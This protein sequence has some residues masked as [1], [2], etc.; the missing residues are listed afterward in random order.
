MIRFPSNT[1]FPGVGNSGWDRYCSPRGF[2]PLVATLVPWLSAAALAMTALGLYVGLV[3]APADAPQGGI[4]RI[5][6]VHVP[7]TWMS[8]FIFLLMAICAGIGLLVQTR[9][10]A[11]MAQALAPTGA[12]FAF[13]ALWTG[14]LWG[15]PAWGAWWI[16][17]VRLIAELVLLVLFLAIMASHAALE[18]ASRADK[19]AAVVALAGA[20]IVPLNLMSVAFWPRIHQNP[21]ITLSGTPDLAVTM[22]IGLLAM[23]AGFWM[24]GSAMALMRLRCVILERERHSDWVTRCSSENWA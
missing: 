19:V 17:D 1:L 11:M 14:S 18:D 23:A 24:Y 22:V 5:V 4:Y 21:S 8:V 20:V 2:Y 3:L 16:W 12:M 10:P 6:F 9:L 7:A 13:M 15:K